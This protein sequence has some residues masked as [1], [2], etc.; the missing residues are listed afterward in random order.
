MSSKTLFIVE[1]PAK[2]KKI[3]SILGPQYTVKASV[4]HIRDLPVHDLGVDLNTLAPTY[5]V[6]KDKK[7]VVSGLKRFL[8]DH[9]HIILA[10]DPDREG[11]AI[12]WHLKAALGLREGTYERVVYQEVTKAGITKALA[13]PRSIDMQTVAAQESRRVLD[14]LIGYLVSPAL[15][16][17]AGTKLSAGRVQSVAV[18]MVVERERAIENFVPLPYK[19]LFLTLPDAPGLKAELR[20][21][22]WAGDEKHVTDPAIVRAL[23]GNHQVR[24]VASETKNSPVKHREP[25]TT[26]TMQ[27]LAGN[28]YG[29]SAKATMQAAQALFEQGRITY[30]RTDNP[31]LSDEGYEKAVAQ[32]QAEGF[33]TNRSKPTFKTSADAQ[34]AHEAIRPTEFSKTEAGDTSDQKNVY[35]IIRERALMLALPEGVDSVANMLFKT[36]EQFTN[37]AG[38]QARAEYLAKGRIV[39]NP[40]WRGALAIEK[41]SAKDNQL[42]NL[43]KGSDFSGVV[44]AQDKETQP[45]SRFTEHSLTK[46]LETAGIGRPSTYAAILENIRNRHYVE[47]EKGA[48]KGKKKTSPP[49]RPTERGCY[50][51]DALSKC[52]FMNYN[53][54]REV[55][56]SLDKIAQGKMAYKGLVGPVLK[57]IQ[58]DI[59]S[60]IEGHSL[61]KESVC[62]LCG[63]AVVQ[64]TNKTGHYWM[65]KERSAGSA[66]ELFLPDE[67]GEPAKPAPVITSQ[68]P[69]C[70]E[71][72]RQM[73]KN[74]NTFWV[75]AEKQQAK[76]CGVTFIND[77]NGKP[78]L[79]EPAKTSLCI[80]CG[81]T[82]TRRYS[83]NNDS[84]FWTHTKKRPKCG[85]YY[86]DDNAGEPAFKTPS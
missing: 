58:T 27:S 79:P 57:Q 39:V 71:P 14:R 31:N 19:S 72:I 13:A 43:Q 21:K 48:G 66:C 54:T 51:V 38:E 36:H 32:A 41:Y 44:Q 56:R 64:Q 49:L 74:G 5:E 61:A 3:S 68:C 60:K 9:D 15:T 70:A 35:A 65:H 24:L 20:A 76:K 47:Y 2:A 55:E 80:E 82:I 4:G 50:I 69:S 77:D 84:H 37:V 34:E 8:R 7:Q 26:V 25:L 16:Q 42:P 10:T 28:L 17:K 29:L 46:A 59:D 63:K 45:P 75:H 53:Y 85:S 12:A 30:H 23:R 73:T 11:E 78:V 52:A 40:G 6:T 62:P 1:S 81:D 83:K 86:V 33:E 18:R 67:N 22:Q